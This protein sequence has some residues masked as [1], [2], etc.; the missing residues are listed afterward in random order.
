MVDTRKIDEIFEKYNGPERPGYAVAVAKDGELFY[1][2]GFGCGNLETGKM[3]E[4]SDV[5]HVASVSKQFTAMCI[6]LL[7]D[8]GLLSVDDCPK[9]YLPY[10]PDIFDDVTIRNMLNHTSGVREHWDLFQF[11]GCSLEDLVT[12]DNMLRL[13]CSQRHKNFEP[14]S[15]YLY[16]NASYLLLGEIVAAVSGKTLRQFADER[17]FKPLGMSKSFFRD[18]HKDIVKDKVYS[19][20]EKDGQW[21]HSV[22][23]FDIVGPT[24][25]NTTALDLIKWLDNWRHPVIC[26]QRV[27]DRMVEPVHLNNGELVA[28]SRGVRITDYRGHQTR[29]HG[30]SNAGYRTQVLSC[31]PWDIVVLGNFSDSMPG[32]HANLV[33]DVLLGLEHEEPAKVEKEVPVFTDLTAQQQ[34]ALTGTWYA[35]E[36]QTIYT[37]VAYSDKLV[38]T[39]MKAGDTVYRQTTADHFISDNGETT[40]DY[41]DGSMFFTRERTRNMEFR[42]I[43]WRSL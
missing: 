43:D 10:L 38:V 41:R 14:G 32:R 27:L 35:D 6:S 8:D 9:K 29:G 26:S 34:A 22:L 12:R 39:H 30:G 33:L 5:F 21:K 11:S 15:E 19:Y 16:C 25:L 17:I 24:S 1:A 13:T 2:K 18:N 28:Y 37:S 23:T 4:P 3:I 31:G 40:M 7:E 20:V 36:L 42:N